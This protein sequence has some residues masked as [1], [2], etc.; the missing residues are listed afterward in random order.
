MSH[1]EMEVMIKCWGKNENEHLTIINGSDDKHIY[2]TTDSDQRQIEI[3]IEE[4]KLA[5]RKMTAK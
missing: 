3:N 2:V 4:L 1:A 5:L